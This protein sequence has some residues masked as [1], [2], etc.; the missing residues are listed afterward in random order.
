MLFFAFKLSCPLCFWYDF[1]FEIITWIMNFWYWFLKLL[2]YTIRHRFCYIKHFFLNIILHLW[3]VCHFLC[4]LMLTCI[5]LLTGKTIRLNNPFSG[6]NFLI[7]LWWFFFIAFIS[8][9]A[10]VLTI[11]F[12]HLVILPLTAGFKGTDLI[13]YA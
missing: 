1:A 12:C 4:D 2:K 8:S 3:I 9:H 5:F 6:S 13:H 7:G 11:L 10:L